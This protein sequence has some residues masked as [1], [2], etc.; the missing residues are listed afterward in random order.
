MSIFNDCAKRGAKLL[1]SIN[2]QWA[3]NVDCE[4]LYMESVSECVLGQ[5]YEDF[6]I[7]MSAIRLSDNEAITHGFTV[8]PR[9]DFD[10]APWNALRD[11][12][13]PLIESR[14]R[15]LGKSQIEERLAA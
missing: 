8:R 13:I 5:C 7:G 12:W 9:K 1:D 4:Y 6:D 3:D 14:Q 11:A 2:P 15:A 10:W